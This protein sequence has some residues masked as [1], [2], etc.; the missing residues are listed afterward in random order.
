MKLK[1]KV[2][3]PC[4]KLKLKVKV[5]CMKL[6]HKVKVPCMKLKHKVKVPC[7]KLKHSAHDHAML[8]VPTTDVCTAW[9]C[10]DIDTIDVIIV[11][12]QYNTEETIE[13]IEIR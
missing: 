12:I 11:T 4:M 6:K 9:L 2:K 10:V 1:L 5:P 8:P 7:M 3:V 13:T